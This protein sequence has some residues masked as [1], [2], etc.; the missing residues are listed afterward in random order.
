M[1][2]S[3]IISIKKLQMKILNWNIAKRLANFRKR[4][5]TSL[6]SKQKKITN[7]RNNDKNYKKRLNLLNRK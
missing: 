4:L 2:A 1:D 5:V 3:K 6:L 7:I